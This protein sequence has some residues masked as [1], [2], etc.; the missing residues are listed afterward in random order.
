MNDTRAY[1]IATAAAAYS[2]SQDTIRTALHITKPGGPIPPLAGK[3]LGPKY[4]IAAEAMEDWF[5]S[6]PDA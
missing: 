6:L 5:R 3:K 4:V 1:S 2:V